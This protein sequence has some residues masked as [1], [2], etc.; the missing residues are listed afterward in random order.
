MLLK[1]RKKEKKLDIDNEKCCVCMKP[2]AIFVYM[3]GQCFTQNYC[4]KKCQE[5]HWK[6]EHWSQCVVIVSQNKKSN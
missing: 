5:V 4:S 2:M 1:H 6:K 3:C